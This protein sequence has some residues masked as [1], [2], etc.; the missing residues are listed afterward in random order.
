VGELVRQMKREKIRALF[1]E[2][3]SNSN[4][5]TQLAKDTDAVIGGT[6]YADALSSPAVPAS[7]YLKMMQLNARTLVTGMKLN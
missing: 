6:L 2:N 4:L 3:M 7:T 5:L 1:L